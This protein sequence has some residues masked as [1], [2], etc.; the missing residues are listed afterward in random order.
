MAP[1]IWM[2]TMV[3]EC[4][5]S[6][7]LRKSTIVNGVWEAGHYV[8]PDICLNNPASVRRIR[9]TP[10]RLIDRVEEL[11]AKCG[12]SVLIKARRLDQL[13][14]GSG[15]VNQS[16]SMARRAASM[17]CSCV[18]PATAPDDNS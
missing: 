3:F 7:V 10:N 15:M 17:T 2:P 9:Y 13:R 12:D 8:A 11:S 14:F 4:K 1:V 5:D 6:D 18:R 16:H